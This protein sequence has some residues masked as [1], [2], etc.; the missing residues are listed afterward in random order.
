MIA[1][2]QVRIIKSTNSY[3]YKVDFNVND[4]I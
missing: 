2:S 4:Y 3:R 1:R